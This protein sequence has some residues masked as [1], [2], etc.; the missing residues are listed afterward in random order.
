[1]IKKIAYIGD[2]HLGISN[3][4]DEMLI[5]LS[6]KMNTT[7]KEMYENG[8]TDVIYTGD[9]F[10]RRKSIPVNIIGWCLDIF[11]NTLK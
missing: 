4:N 11:I 9:F 5:Y 6:S 2:F 10:D 3:G 1:M 8:I 7:I